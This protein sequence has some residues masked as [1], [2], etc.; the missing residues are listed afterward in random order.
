MFKPFSFFYEHEG[1]HILPQV[2]ASWETTFQPSR[3]SFPAL[4]KELQSESRAFPDGLLGQGGSSA[5]GYP[6]FLCEKSSVMRRSGFFLKISY[7]ALQYKFPSFID[8][9]SNARSLSESPLVD[10]F[11]SIKIVCSIHTANKPLSRTFLNSCSS[12]FSLYLRT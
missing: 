11:G 2:S 10:K 7:T 6:N 4:R 3:G 8:V 12:L 5:T 9:P 1:F